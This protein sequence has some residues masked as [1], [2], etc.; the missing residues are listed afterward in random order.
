MMPNGILIHD[1]RYA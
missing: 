1:G